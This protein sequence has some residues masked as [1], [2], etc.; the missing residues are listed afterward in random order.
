MK[1]EQRVAR[2]AGRRGENNITLIAL[3][4]WASGKGLKD[5]TIW[6]TS[7]K[8]LMDLCGI[9]HEHWENEQM[10]IMGALAPSLEYLHRLLMHWAPVYI[11]GR[12]G[13]FCELEHPLLSEPALRNLLPAWAPWVDKDLL[14]L[15]S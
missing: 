9:R 3:L 11:A 5:I 1:L 15:S 6:L 8:A 10:G 4:N 13:W 14:T 12:L 2:F 7:E